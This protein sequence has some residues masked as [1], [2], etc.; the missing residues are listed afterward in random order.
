MTI[1]SAT[2]RSSDHGY[3]F[4]YCQRR[5]YFDYLRDGRWVRLA[6]GYAGAGIGVN[7]PRCQHIRS[8]GPL[9]R[10]HYKMA[11]VDHPR[12]A[13]PAIRLTQET[14]ET[15]GRSGFW[16]HGDNRHLNRTAS[17]GCIVINLLARR[18]LDGLMRLVS[19]P[20]LL[21]YDSGA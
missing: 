1:H 7:V 5:G 6:T 15:F 11:V 9:P 3:Q 2:S 20:T 4:R 12:F 16:V 18:Q 17:T 8:V 19:R 21:V 14:G 13:A 10:G